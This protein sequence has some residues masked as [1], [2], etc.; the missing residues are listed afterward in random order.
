MDRGHSH[1]YLQPLIVIIALELSKLKRHSYTGP[2]YPP[3]M[4]KFRGVTLLAMFE[5]L[6]KGIE[7][8]Q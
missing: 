7:Y 4:A 6:F 1:Q 8:A 5:Q 2:L 3:L